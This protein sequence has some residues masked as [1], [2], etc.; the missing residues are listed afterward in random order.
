[1]RNLQRTKSGMG[2][3]KLR[4]SVSRKVVRKLLRVRVG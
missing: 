2:V 4:D 3:P 1:M